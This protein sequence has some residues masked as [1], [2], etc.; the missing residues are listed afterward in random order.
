MPSSINSDNGAVS[1]S[2]GLKYAADATGNLVLQTNTVN[3]V[4]IDTNQNVTLNSTGAI[5]LNAGNSAQRPTGAN[6]MLRYSTTTNSFEGYA[7][8]AWGAIGGAAGGGT[9]WQNVITSNTTVS[10]G[11][12]YPVNTTSSSIVVTLPSSPGAGNLIQLT[13]YART[14]NSNSVTLNPNGNKIQGSTSNV[15]LNINGQSVSLVYVDS[16][17]GWLPSFN[18]VT[19][20]AN[21]T[22]TYLVVAGGAGGGSGGGGA[23]GL[24]YNTY[25]VSAGQS[26]GITVGGGGAGGNGGALKGTNGTNSAFSSIAVAIG[27]GY[28]TA[29]DSVG[30]NGGSGGGSGAN[31]GAVLAGGSGTAGQGNPGGTNGTTSANYPAGG[32]GGAGATGQNGVNGSQGGAG[33]AGA[34]YSISGASVTY[35]GGGGGGLYGTGSGGSGG[36]G[37]G[38]A[39]GGN[40]TGGGGAGTLN[41]GG[42]GGGAANA[43]AGGTGGSG[44]VI[45]SYAGSQRGTGGTITTVGGNT[46]HTFTGS[47]TFTA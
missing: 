14:W 29:T 37:G 41:T 39:G 15:I 27:G 44:I 20:L 13:D 24:L 2:A 4:T 8:G 32:G 18:S 42:G 23:G 47:G 7:A 19:Q 33:G 1:G 6:G 38:G 40:N 9:T 17:Q 36:A 34:A 12:A 10:V 46:I 16:T 43:G 11:N 28:G 35:A 31:G 3:A 30:G 22:V 45:I 25:S 26:Y 21:Y 5:T